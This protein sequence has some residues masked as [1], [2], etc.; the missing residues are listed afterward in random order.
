ML[1]DTKRE[2]ERARGRE[3]ERERENTED[4]VVSRSCCWLPNPRRVLCA[5]GVHQRDVVV[6]FFNKAIDVPLFLLSLDYACTVASEL[7]EIR[8]AVRYDKAVMRI[9]DFV[10]PF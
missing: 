10:I 2:R 5:F 7:G 9:G 1:F 4:T 3:R 6:Q 8:H